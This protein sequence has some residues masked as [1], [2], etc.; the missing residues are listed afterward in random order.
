MNLLPWDTPLDKRIAEVNHAKK[1]GFRVAFYFCE[2]SNDS[3]FR[4]R[5]YNI[6]QHLQKSAK[7]KAFYFYESEADVVK[8]YLNLADIF[9]IHRYRWTFKLEEI[10][11]A[12]KG[13]GIPV[14][15]DTD[16]LVYDLDYAPAFITTLNEAENEHSYNSHFQYIG[17]QA[18][19]MQKG[20]RF[21]ATNGY[22]AEQIRAKFNRP[23]YVI[24]N[25][26]NSEQ[27]SASQ[28]APKKE[29]N[30]FVMGY[31][32]G[33]PTHYNDFCTIAPE[34]ANFLEIY[35]NAKLLVAGYM[36]IPDVLRKFV[37]NGQIQTEK[38][39]NF[40]KLQSLIA[41][42]DVNLIPL[43]DNVFTNCKSEL[44]FFEA[45]VVS[46]PSIATPVYVYKNCITD[47]EN[48]FL[49]RQGQWFDRLEQLYHDKKNG[50]DK[51]RNTALKAK[52]YAL[53]NYYGEKMLKTIEDV[54]DLVF[55]SK[56]VPYPPSKLA[57][58]YLKGLKGIEIG[59]SAH[60]Q[61]YLNTINIDY[62]DKVT[63]YGNDQ[64][65][66][67]GGTLK[68]DIVSNGD[69]LPFKDNV[70]DFVINSHVL[71]HFWDPIKTINEWLRII[72]SGG[73]LFMNIPH[74]ERTFDKDRPRTTLQE[75]IDRHN[76]IGQDPLTHAHHSVW[77]TQDLLELCKYMN[78]NVI[79]HL[80]I[81]DKV[82]NGFTILIQK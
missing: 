48:G 70:W 51:L 30:D 22:L 13:F 12:V 71:E 42:V 41:S 52:E 4:Y 16:D 57:N 50:G 27:I 72:K 65:K 21:I 49:C 11:H 28:N 5:V 82:G 68:V 79:E 73:Y 15:C 23:V 38:F 56:I 24:P 60:N 36:K 74:K 58:K 6:Y 20:Q 80:D 78:L 3:S 33:S 53:Q 40:K 81:D 47:G 61:F 19:S 18:V 10:Y 43:V 45:A 76:G 59:G 63:V 67:A 37:K 75:L 1:S 55:I 69:D 2:G 44:K 14:A 7:W 64:F 8:E 54:F 39:T 26:L 46:V 62:T 29:N 34:I 25:S 31:F 77:V 32:S 66:Y 35:G 17:R 9:I